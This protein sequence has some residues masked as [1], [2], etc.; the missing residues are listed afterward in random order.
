M[1]KIKH[2]PADYIEEIEVWLSSGRFLSEYCRQPGKPKVTTIH[3]WLVADSSLDERV[4]RAR[5]RGAETLFEQNLEIADAEPPRDANGRIDPGFV[6]WHKNRI[7]ARME[8]L[9]K[10]NPKKYGDK[11]ENTLQGPDGAPLSLKVTFGT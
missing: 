10:I 11:V 9:K 1:A 5:E 2:Q 7:W 6:A 4:A 8:M 3:G